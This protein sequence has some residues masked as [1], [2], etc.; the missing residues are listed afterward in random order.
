MPVAIHKSV[1]AAAARAR[2]A[3]EAHAKAA[4][5]RFKTWQ[6]KVDAELQRAA[7][8]RGCDVGE[9]AG[10]IGPRRRR[11]EGRVRQDG[12]KAERR[13]RR[14]RDGNGGGSGGGNGGESGGGNGGGSG[15]G[16]GDASSSS[17]FYVVRQFIYVSI[18]LSDFSF[19]TVECGFNSGD[20]FE[21]LARRL[22]EV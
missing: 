6:S 15:G 16:Y 8:R 7:H 5:A 2:V 14:E 3:A 10:A 4:A 22:V 9:A 1:R 21:D 20:A 13:W 12:S 19:D 18:Q 11:R 17:F